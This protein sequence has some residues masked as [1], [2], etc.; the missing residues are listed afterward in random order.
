MI[1]RTSSS[2]DTSSQLGLNYTSFVDKLDA[3][4]I[5]YEICSNELDKYR[6]DIKKQ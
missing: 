6:D 1:I 4:K 3:T 2:E 5:I